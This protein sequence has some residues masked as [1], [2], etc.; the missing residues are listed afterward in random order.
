M[1]GEGS[2]TDMI[3]VLGLGSMTDFPLQDCPRYWTDIFPLSLATSTGQDKLDYDLESGERDE[4]K[5][6]SLGIY[7]V[8]VAV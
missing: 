6:L 8:A 4:G 7:R 1:L 5:I 3:H 2:T